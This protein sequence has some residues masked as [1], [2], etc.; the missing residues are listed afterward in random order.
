MYLYAGF[1]DSSKSGASF[2]FVCLYSQQEWG[3]MPK[4][5]NDDDDIDVMVS[6]GMSM[7][8]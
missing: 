7:D 8:G 5:D 4:K 1:V 6:K 2:F 3:M